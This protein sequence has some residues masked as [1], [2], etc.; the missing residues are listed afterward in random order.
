[1]H[2]NSNVHIENFVNLIRTKKNLERPYF[3]GYLTTRT[4]HYNLDT[5]HFDLFFLTFAFCFTSSVSRHKSIA[6]LSSNET[7]RY[8][9]STLNN[10]CDLLLPNAIFSK[11]Q[12][13]KR[14]RFHHLV[15]LPAPVNINRIYRSNVNLFVSL[16]VLSRRNT[17]KVRLSFH[18][19]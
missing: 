10:S 6:S 16:R 2:N 14:S 19:S 4:N 9:V 3:V 15:S 17:L 1:M 13:V 11:K 12:T 8:N 5:L 7:H 18:H